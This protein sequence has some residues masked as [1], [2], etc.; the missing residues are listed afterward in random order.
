MPERPLPRARDI[1]TVRDWVSENS[2]LK[3]GLVGAKPPAFCYWI[4]EL[5]GARPEDEFFDLFPGTGIVTRC[6]QSWCDMKRCS[7][8]VMELGI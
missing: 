8:E 7:Q 6:W 5:L 1:R 2:T 3:K 4:F